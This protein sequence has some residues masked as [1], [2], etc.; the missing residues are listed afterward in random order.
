M[1]IH[2]CTACSGCRDEFKCIYDDDMTEIYPLITETD[3]ITISAPLYFSSFPSPLKAFIDRCQV[4]WE[5]KERRGDNIK[6]GHGFLI[7]AGGSVYSNMFT[8][9]LLTVKHFFNSISVNYSA[10]DSILYS[11]TDS[12]DEISLEIKD[13]ARYTGEE[14]IKKYPLL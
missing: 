1:N 11:G 6:R 12:L 14:F 9:V 5:L 7:A 3:F 2:P 13:K 10:D 8:G 4:L